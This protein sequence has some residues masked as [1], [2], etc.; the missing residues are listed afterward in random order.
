MDFLSPSLLDSVRRL[1]W[2][3]IIGH[4][5]HILMSLSLEYARQTRARHDCSK[6]AHYAEC[7]MQ[8]M[9][10]QTSIEYAVD[11]TRT[12]RDKSMYEWW[13]N[14]G[15][16]NTEALLKGTRI[17]VVR[18]GICMPISIPE[19][20]FIQRKTASTCSVVVG[21]HACGEWHASLSPPISTVRSM[22]G[23]RKEGCRA[24]KI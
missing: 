15:G 9:V 18:V 22:A 4:F 16:D 23:G 2:P 7:R 17:S 8:D 21:R 6:G 1:D 24:T 11:D 10:S 20:S 19:N 12:M 5:E 13:G 14:W 3:I